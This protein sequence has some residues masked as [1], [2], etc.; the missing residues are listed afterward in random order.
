MFEASHP[1]GFFDYFRIPYDIQIP[2]DGHPGPSAAVGRLRVAGPDDHAARSLLWLRAD[3]GAAGASAGGKLGRY[4][5]RDNTL[6]GL[7]A[8]DAAVPPLLQQLGRGWQRAEPI[9]GADGRRV[10]ATWRDLDGNVFLPFDPAEVMQRFWSEQY[11]TVGRSATSALG[12]AVALRGYYLVRPALPRP[13]QLTLRRA[14]TRVQ[15]RSAF[16]GWPVEDT[17]HNLYQ[18]L[19]GLVADFAGRPVP[20]LELWP[21]GRSWALVLTHDVETNVGYRDINR[22]RSLEHERGYCSSWNFVALRYRVGDDVVRDLQDSG[23]EVGVHG[24]RHD[25]RDLGSRRLLEKRLPA[26]RSYAQRWNAVG[27]RSPG[28]QRE[29]ELMP[30]LGFEYDSSYTDTDPY[31]PQPGG[32]CTYLPYL[33]QGMVELPITLPQ[34]HTMFAVLQHP[35]ADVWLRKAHHVRERRGLVLVLT[36]PDYARD[37]PRITEGYRKLL[38]EFRGDDTVWHALPRDVAAWWRRRAASSLRKNGDGWAIE[39]PASADGRV[40][41]ATAGR[42]GADPGAAQQA[43]EHKPGKA[44]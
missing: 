43:P 30:R 34:D 41:L 12:R 6:V 18:W 8:L 17:L 19:F 29:W 32:C 5:L 28:T 7:V 11:R 1:F 25:G 38:D 26:M 3:A 13:L 33:N 35:D 44:T 2:S 16:P 37:D 27:F 14:F 42:A 15:S 21:H 39:G 9:L 4:R 24:L 23:F 10:A 36:H 20:F 22:L 31:E 40:G